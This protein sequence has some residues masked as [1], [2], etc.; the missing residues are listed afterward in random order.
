MDTATQINTIASERAR[1]GW[2]Q[3]DLGMKVGKDRKTV[4]R[5]EADPS[6]MPIKSL[7]Q[8]SKLFNCST[9]YLLGLVD[10][11]APYTKSVA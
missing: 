5:W 1:L 7:L 10:E 9:D 4:A 6:S 8:L 11:R 2:S 3:T